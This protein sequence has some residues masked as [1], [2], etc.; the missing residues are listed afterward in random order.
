V[1][2]G[3]VASGI[4][5]GVADDGFTAFFQDAYPRIV[6]QLR[7]LTGDL[8]SAEDVAQEAFVRAASRWPQLARYDQP[9]AWVRRTAFRLAVDL[10]RRARRQRRL[11]ARLGTRREADAELHPQDRAVVDALLRLPLPLREVLVLHHCLDLPVEAV[12]AQTGVSAGTVKSRLSRGR[13]R[14]AALLHPDQSPAVPELAPGPE[15]DRHAR[16]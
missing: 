6:G 1:F 8:A 15:E 3:T 2:R 7:L 13:E 4:G 10:L 5:A 14:L 12:A 16:P 9:E 11:L